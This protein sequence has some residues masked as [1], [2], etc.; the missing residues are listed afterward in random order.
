M[1]TEY[2]FD[3]NIVSDLYKDAYGMRPTCG[4]WNSWNDGS[5]E[6]RQDMWDG[7][8]R[9]LD[10][11]M[12]EQARAYTMHAADVEKRI[13]LTL[14][15]VA[16]ATRADAVRYLHDA[17]GTDGDDGYLEYHLGLKYGYFART[18]Q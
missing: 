7:L 18:A 8:I 13:A 14:E 10:V 9:D 3:A 12:N 6:D 4:F 11:S 1:T 2:T 17:Y 5:D 15:M 16:G